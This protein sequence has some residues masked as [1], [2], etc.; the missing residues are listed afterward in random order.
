MFIRMKSIVD[1][2]GFFYIEF[3]CISLAALLWTNLPG[4]SWHPILLVIA[5]VLS[6]LGFGFSIYYFLNSIWDI[7][8]HLYQLYSQLGMSWIWSRSAIIQESIQP[9]D[10]VGIAAITL[11]FSVAL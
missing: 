8:P 5:T 11:P 1:H 9:D 6:L 10:I 4:V 2:S 3:T 7:E